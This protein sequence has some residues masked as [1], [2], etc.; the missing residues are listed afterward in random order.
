MS[1]YKYQHIERLET[2]EVKGINIGTTYIFPKIDGT[3]GSVW[4]ED[5]K[6][7]CGSRNRTLSASNDNQ[8]FYKYIM[9]NEKIEAYLNKYPNHHIFGEF[10]IPH[11]LKTY[12]DTAWNKFYIF[13]IVIDGKHIDYPTYKEWLN[14][15]EL[16]YIPCIA[17]L[18]NPTK[19]KLFEQLNK[20]TFLIKDGEGIGEGIVIKNYGYHNQYGRET[21]AKIVR[22]EFKDNFHKRTDYSSIKYELIEQK[23]IDKFLTEDIVNK[24]YANIKSQNDGW[25]SKFIPRLLNTVFYDLIREEM[26]EILK[27]FKYPTIDFQLLNKIIINKIKEIKKEL[28]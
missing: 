10:L 23:I 3:N 25:S 27:K 28:F 15:F 1:F 5:D 14:E 8:G 22:N 9:N 12:R 7:Y 26:W 6:I 21:W 4:L 16:L 24:V 20:A 17:I 18:E 19:D 11:T 13:D 2:I